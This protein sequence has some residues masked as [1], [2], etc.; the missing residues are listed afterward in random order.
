M[1]YDLNLDDRNYHEIESDAVFH[2]P[3][4]YPEWTNYNPSDP[5]I[6]LVQLFSWLKEVQQYHINQLGEKKKRKYLKLLGAEIGHIRPACGAVCVEPGIGANGNPSCLYKGTRFW[7]GDMPFETV[8][9]ERIHPTRMIGAYMVGSDYMSS[10]QSMGNDFEKQIRLFPFG[11]QPESGNRC[12]FVLDRGLDTKSQTEVYF[13][14]RTEYEV[15][16]NPADENFI[17][18]AELKWEYYSVKGWQELHLDSDGTHDLIQSGSIKFRISEE[19]IPDETVGAFQFR[20][21]LLEN[22]YDIAPMIRNIYLNE[23]SLLQQYTVCDYEDFTVEIC[24][25]EEELSVLSSM[26]LAAAGKSEIYV[27]T[28]EGWIP[29][30]ITEKEDTGESGVRIRFRRPPRT[31][32]KLMQCRLCVYEPEA[33]ARRI[34]GEGSAFANQEY[35]LHLSGIVYDD[36]EIMVFDPL[37]GTYSVYEKKEDFDSSLPEDRH[38]IL[39]PDKEKICFGDCERGMAPEGEIRIIRLKISAGK[40]GNIKADKIRECEVSPDLI[41]KQFKQT[42]GG[43]DEETLEQCFERFRTEIK[44]ASRG[45]TY[46]DYEE[47]V[48]KTPGLLI[49]D[50][51]VIPPAEWIKEGELP[52]E[53]QISIVVHPLSFRERNACLNERYRQNL[54]QMLR[55][56]KMIGTRIQILNP[57]YIGISVYAEIVIRPQYQDAEK[58]IGEAVRAYLDEKSWEIGQPV[59]GSTIYGII[60]TLPCV[61]MVRTMTLDAVGKGCRRLVNG[62]VG[63]PPNGLAYLKELDFNIYTA[64]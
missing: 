7:A 14:I 52:A 38:Y 61:W 23:I 19:M 40:S 16:R 29:A 24:E 45:V 15:L 17:S 32:G 42:E 62:D 48:R 9:K 18:L 44:G 37:A 21:T 60:D 20:V 46:A 55:K 11:E 36:F 34:V 50:C 13:D 1:L 10:Y 3:R 39:Y 27:N 49:L 54:E 31:G 6:T 58:Q 64:D 5:G 28:E 12:Y 43:R 25:D 47:L 8:R 4:E 59:L 33:A 35:D 41:V 63:L 56:R 53:N 2:I 26:F 57:E 22:N 51:R 30:E